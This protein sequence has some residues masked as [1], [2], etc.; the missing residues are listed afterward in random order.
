M[1]LILIQSLEHIAKSV[2]TITLVL[3]FKARPGAFN[4]LSLLS[5]F[6]CFVIDTREG[7]RL[8][9]ANIERAVFDLFRP[10]VPTRSPFPTPRPSDALTSLIGF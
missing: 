9:G 4:R 8:A 2:R 6:G 5:L 10:P 7:V 1:K 3:D